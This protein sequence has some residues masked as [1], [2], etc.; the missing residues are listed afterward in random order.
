MSD[1]NQL[2]LAIFDNETGADNAA[3][4]IKSWDKASEQIKLGGVG[5][6]VKAENGKIKQSKIGQRQGRKGAGI[7]MALGII[8]AIPTGGLSLAAGAAGGAAGGGILGSPYPKGFKVSKED[9]QR[10]DQALNEGH[11]AVG[12][13]VTD[14]EAKAVTEKLT[15]L[16]GEVESHEVTDEALQAAAKAGEPPET[17]G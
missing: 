14:Y 12:V 17:L 4:A 16:G 3:E 6:L 11:A 9:A 15:Q 8:A 5:V 13:M 1:T 2:I 7:G 10:L